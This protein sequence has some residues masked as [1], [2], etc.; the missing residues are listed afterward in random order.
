MD[1]ELRRVKALSHPLRIQ[2]LKVINASQSALPV[3]RVA[4]ILEQAPSKLHYHFKQLET[5]GFIEV[6]D[7]REVNGI[8]ERFYSPTGAE[9][10]L[11]LSAK[12]NP[13]AVLAVMPMMERRTL[14]AIR[15][16]KDLTP[17]NARIG[18]GSVGEIYVHPEKALETKQAL[19][20]FLDYKQARL[21]VAADEQTGEI[22][23]LIVFLVPRG[24]EERNP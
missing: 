15:R 18:M 12:D 5:A 8:T 11:H 3:K 22:Y 10:D 1:Q 7:T 24:T 14:E 9:M 21:P 17:E 20:D 4:D 13:D 16:L 6:T 2:I 23:D 19:G